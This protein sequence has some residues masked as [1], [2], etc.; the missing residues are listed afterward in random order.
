MKLRSL[1]AVTAAL[2]LAPVAAASASPSAPVAAAHDESSHPGAFI[3]TYVARYYIHRDGSVDVTIDFA[4]DFNGEPG[5]GPYLSFPI[6]APYDEN[7]DLAYRMSDF[8]VSSPT[9]APTDVLRE[10]RGDEVYFRVGNPSIGNLRGVQRYHVTYTVDGLLDTVTARDYDPAIAPEDDVPLWDEFFVNVLG[11]GWAIPIDSVSVFV[12]G[13]AKAVAVTPPG[14]TDAIDARCYVGHPGAKDP[15]LGAWLTD[16]VGAFSQA[17]V[18]PGQAMT[19]A[20]AFPAG[21]FDTKPVLRAKNPFVQAYSVTPLTIAGFVGVLALSGAWLYWRVRRRRRSERYAGVIPGLAPV[22]GDETRVIP[23]DSRT[24]VAVQFE[25]PVGLRPGHLGTLIDAKAD[26]RDIT[27]TIVDLAV[28]GY[29]RIDGESV[30]HSDYRFIRLKDADDSLLGYEKEIYRA[31]FG[32]FYKVADEADF[33]DLA[34]TFAVDLD[35]FEHQLMDNVTRRGWFRGSP[36]SARRRWVASGVGVV[37]LGVAS[38]IALAVTSSWA[39]VPLPLVLVGIA[40]MATSNAAPARTAEG[41]RILTQTRGFQTFLSTSDGEMLRFEEKSDIF[42]EYLPFAIALGVADQWTERFAKLAADGVKLAELQWLGS[43]SPLSWG[44][45][46][47]LRRRIN[48]VNSLAKSLL[49]YHPP[50]A[51]WNAGLDGASDSGRSFWGGFGGGSGR[52][53]G[54]SFRGGGFSRGGR[55]GG[56]RFGGGGGRW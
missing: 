35:H 21:S 55:S 17:D 18:S 12:E 56:G 4:F 46:I 39:I 11:T 45:S 42:S 14:T 51:N 2:V 54:G 16:G 23:G 44:D 6:R 13:D 24:P 5:H 37:L 33:A 31:L 26:V 43:S 52:R 27:A 40:T 19:V 38:S 3:E 15:C 49:A 34:L 29:I 41:T 47:V 36:E 53:F 48:G 10:V 9:G 30:E 7:Y 20:L 22:P 50:V 32:K 25:P 8:R 1:V 28:R